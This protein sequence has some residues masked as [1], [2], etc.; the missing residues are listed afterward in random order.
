M[1]LAGDACVM[2]RVIAAAFYLYVITTS[3]RV[4]TNI[5]TMNFESLLNLVLF[6]F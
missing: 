5:L 6:P 3:L 1:K 2:D 4:K